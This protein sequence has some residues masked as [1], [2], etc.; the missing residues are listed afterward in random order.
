M[1]L[2]L[3]GVNKS[4]GNK[5]P[6][7]RLYVQAGLMGKLQSVC[8]SSIFNHHAFSTEKQKDAAG[9]AHKEAC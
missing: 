4:A 1:T 6:A 8:Q 7:G 5:M 9:N 3:E 2:S